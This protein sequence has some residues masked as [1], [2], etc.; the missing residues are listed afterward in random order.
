MRVYGDSQSMMKIYIYNYVREKIR[1]IVGLQEPL[2]TTLKRRKLPWFAH[3][4]QHD[5]LPKTILQGT[6]EGGKCRNRQRKKWVKNVKEWTNVTV[7]E[8]LTAASRN[9]DGGPCQ[10]LL[11]S[12]P[13]TTS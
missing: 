6:V 10:L 11:P 1:Y 13:P 9:R 5:T 3:V 12:L 7:P 2:L 4:T 8:L